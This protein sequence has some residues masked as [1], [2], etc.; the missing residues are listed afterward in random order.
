MTGG[1][2]IIDE[3]KDSDDYGPNAPCSKCGKRIDY[4][5]PQWTEYCFNHR[6]WRIDPFTVELENL[7]DRWDDGSPTDQA[8]ADE[9]RAV[10][11]K[12]K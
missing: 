5:S 12:Y 10:I 11:N 8:C 2:I 6:E 3:R 4:Y 9:L 1:E 7:V